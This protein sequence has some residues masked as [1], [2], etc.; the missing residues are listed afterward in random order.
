MLGDIA[1]EITALWSRIVTLSRELGEVREENARLRQ[2]IDQITE[3]E[4][5]GRGWRA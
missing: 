3:R 1:R 5:E 4:R 2:E